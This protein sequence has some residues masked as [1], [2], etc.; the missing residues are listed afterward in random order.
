[1][2]LLGVSPNYA[3]AVM[4][5]ALMGLTSGAGITPMMGLLAGWFPV[6][7]RGL[8]AGFASA[9]GSTAFILSGAIAP[10]L[11]ARSIENG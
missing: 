4:A 8:A 1:M 2:V 6:R 9:G 5:M 11:T 7:T 3:V 10:F